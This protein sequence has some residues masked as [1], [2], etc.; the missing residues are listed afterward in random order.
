MSDRLGYGS[1]PFASVV[2]RINDVTFA[3]GLRCNGVEQS[4]VVTKNEVIS[5]T[6]SCVMLP[7]I[8]GRI[9]GAAHRG[10]LPAPCPVSIALS[11][12]Y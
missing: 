5:S 8:R 11:S 3:N 4:N 10:A 7:A 2:R 6:L 9:V 12:P 1:A